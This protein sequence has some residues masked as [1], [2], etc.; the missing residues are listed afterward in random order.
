M[1]AKKVHVLSVFNGASRMF[2]EKL[3]AQLLPH[4]HVPSTMSLSVVRLASGCSLGIFLQDE[5]IHPH[6]VPAANII[7]TKPS[8]SLAN[9]GEYNGMFTICYMTWISS[10]DGSITS[11]FQ[12]PHCQPSPQQRKRPRSTISSPR[13]INCASQRAGCQSKCPLT[14]SG[15]CP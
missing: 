15:N 6:V 4:W 8:K 9:S 7:R 3:S 14:T 11:S 2:V 1:R 12:S 13:I 5:L 10:P